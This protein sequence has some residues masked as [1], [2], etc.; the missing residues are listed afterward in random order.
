MGGEGRAPQA[1]TAHSGQRNRGAV[2]GCSAGRQAPAAGVTGPLG[3]REG[4]AQVG[5]CLSVSLRSCEEPEKKGQPVNKHQSSPSSSQPP[6]SVPG[7]ATRC[8]CLAFQLIS[9]GCRFPSSCGTSPPPHLTA[10][11]HPPIRPIRVSLYF[12][13]P[14]SFPSTQIPPPHTDL[15]CKDPTG[16]FPAWSGRSGLSCPRSLVL[17]S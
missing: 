5:G 16:S 11:R 13:S 17:M 3:P 15:P 9:T 2:W 14:P 10:L 6:H 12:L 7:I 8:L 1:L 4:G